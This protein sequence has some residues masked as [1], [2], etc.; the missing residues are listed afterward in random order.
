MTDDAKVQ[1]LI[2]MLKVSDECVEAGKCSMED[3]Q[4]WLDS[5]QGT[6][7]TEMLCVLMSGNKPDM[8]EAEDE[9]ADI[10]EFEVSETGKLNIIA[11]CVFSICSCVAFF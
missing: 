2:D 9:E 10:T 1:F 11:G 6:A 4:A 8:N 7:G 3:Q 5:I